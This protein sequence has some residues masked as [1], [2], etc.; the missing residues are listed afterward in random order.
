[1]K[2]CVFRKVFTIICNNFNFKPF[3]ATFDPVRCEII[4]SCNVHGRPCVTWIR[5]DHTISNNRYRA[6]EE[7]GGVRKLIIRNPIPSDCGTFSCF[8]ETN[9]G[10]ESITKVIKIA[11]LKK[12]M[13]AAA[14]S[15]TNGYLNDS[16]TLNKKASNVVEML[17][18]DIT[19]AKRSTYG[20]NQQTATQRKPLFSTLLH[21]RTVAE[22]S[23]VRL[24][25]S[26][27]YDGC[28]AIEWLK[29]SQPLPKDNRY[30]TIF[31]NG[32]A[33]LEIFGAD[34][35]DSGR[36]TCR[37]TNDYGES[38]SHSHLRVFKHYED[39]PQPTTFV[40]SIK[41]IY[42]EICIY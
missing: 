31:H 19:S 42:N 29:D 17:D 16:E 39:A 12:L 32:E 37:A 25:C 7:V 14:E 35:K 24:C 38:V 36:Y 33:I 11:D 2:A 4:L 26:V 8:A 30:Q 6:V 18:N 23:N 20:R 22:C 21:D 1:M 34:E 41:G 28:T 9:E 3:L 10:I 13:T 15:E 5:D 27:V 40:Q